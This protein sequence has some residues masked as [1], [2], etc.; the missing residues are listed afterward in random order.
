MK[1]LFRKILVG[2]L[3]LV[4]VF[5]FGGCGKKEKK[6]ISIIQY[7]SATALDNAKDGIIEGLGKMLKSQFTT[8]KQKLTL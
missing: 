3:V 7:V 4:S 5:V 6:V 8:L 2:C 1:N